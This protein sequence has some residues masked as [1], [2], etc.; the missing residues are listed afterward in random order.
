MPLM[1][2]KEIEALSV[3]DREYKLVDLRAELARIRT[4]VNAGG[5]VED[6]TRIRAIRKTIAQ[7]LTV[8][9]E[10]RMGLRKAPKEPEKKEK[11]KKTKAKQTTEEPATQ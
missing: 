1:R 6:P 8:Q 5:A 9:N 7:I 2:I 3:Q 10:T 4:M 11:A